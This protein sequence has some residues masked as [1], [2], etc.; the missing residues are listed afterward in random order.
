[1]DLK[2]LFHV[3]VFRVFDSF[4]IITVL[5]TLLAACTEVREARTRKRRRVVR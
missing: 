1:M 2:H 4:L 3:G 5:T